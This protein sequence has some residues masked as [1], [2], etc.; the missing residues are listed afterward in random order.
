MFTKEDAFAQ[1]RE[2]AAGREDYIYELPEDELIGE[3]AYSTPAGEPSCIVGQV[4]HKYVPDMYQHVHKTEWDLDEAQ[5][6]YGFNARSVR[7]LQGRFLEHYDKEAVNV[8]DKVQRKQ[9]NGTPWGEA[10]AHVE[11]KEV[12]A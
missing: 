1:L 11:G 2:V 8:L 3:C 9:D 12:A 6:V 5:E 4:L 10:I 7:D